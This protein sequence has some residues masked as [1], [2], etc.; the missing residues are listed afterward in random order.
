MTLYLESDTA[1]SV[2]QSTGSTIELSTC[3]A[4]PGVRDSNGA[5]I[6]SISPACPLWLRP[7]GPRPNMRSVTVA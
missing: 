4:A 6:T 7:G 5:P 2:E 3:R 1:G